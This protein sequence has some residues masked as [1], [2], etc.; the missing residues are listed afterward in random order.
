LADLDPRILSPQQR[1]SLRLLAVGCND[2][3]IAERMRISERTVRFHVTAAVRKLG[4]ESRA[5]AVVLAFDRREIGRPRINPLRKRI[6][7][8][9]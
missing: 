3:V 8:D 6:T 2:K 4:A 7:D 1:R 9:E 5:H